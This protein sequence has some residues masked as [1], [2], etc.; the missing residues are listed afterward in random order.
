MGRCSVD[1][2]CGGEFAAIGSGQL[3][4]NCYFG[5]PIPVP[6]G[7]LSACVVNTFLTD[8]YGSVN[9]LPPQA[10]LTTALSSRVYFNANPASPCPRCEDGVCTGGDRAGQSCTAVGS[11]HTSLDCPPTAVRSSVH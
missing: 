10:T 5:P 1:T 8:L 3:K 7:G 9:L 11:A 4:A 6:N 2:D